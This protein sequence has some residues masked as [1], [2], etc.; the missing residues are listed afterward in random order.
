MSQLKSWEFWDD[1]LERAVKTMAQTAVATIGTAV[2]ISQVDWWAVG[3]ATLLAGILSILTS[4][5]GIGRSDTV[6]PASLVKYLGPES[7]PRHARKE[8]DNERD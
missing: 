3:G 7:T 8:E 6:S 2:V 4:I 5:A 1:A